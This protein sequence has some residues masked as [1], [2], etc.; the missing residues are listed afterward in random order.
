[1]IDESTIFTIDNIFVNSY[2]KT[3]AKLESLRLISIAAFFSLLFLP[4]FL[5]FEEL[6]YVFKNSF[7]FVVKIDLVVYKFP[8]DGIKHIAPPDVLNIDIETEILIANLTI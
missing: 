2:Y 5:Q 3:L 7:T 4:L 6:T 8:V 1:M